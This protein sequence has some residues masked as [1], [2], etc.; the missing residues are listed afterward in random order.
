MEVSA[1]LPSTI[2]WHSDT[3]IS[4]DEDKNK[5]VCEASHLIVTKVERGF[6]S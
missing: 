5:M 1:L 6:G 4:K 2:R 3:N